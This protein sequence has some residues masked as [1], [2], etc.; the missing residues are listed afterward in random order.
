MSGNQ[1][2]SFF[3]EIQERFIWTIE[4]YLP[5]GLGNGCFKIRLLPKQ[6]NQKCPYCDYGKTYIHEH[7]PREI[8]GG[9]F[10]GV[11]VL[12]ALDQL[13]HM[14]PICGGTFV[15]IYDCVP[16][17]HGN[18]EE[19]E[20]Y[21]L[22]MLGSMPMTMI[23]SHL[24]LS[25]QTI[26]NRAKD[27]ADDEQKVM[28]N[29][30]YRYLSMDEVYIGRK[31]DGSHRIYWT[32]NDNSIPWKSNNVM[33]KIGR[34]KNEVIEYL[35]QLKHGDKVIAVS[36]DMWSAYRDAIHEALP[37]A[38]VVIDRYHVTE[39]AE[40]V[41]KS[42]LTSIVCPKEVKEALKEDVPLFLK[43]WLKLT[44][45]ELNSL[46]YYFSHDKRLEEVYYLIQEFMDFYN[47]PDYECALEYI[48][49]W[50]SKLFASN[51]VEEIRPLYDTLFNW[52][53]YI[54]NYFLY[55]ITNGR[56]EGKNNLLRQIDRMGFHYGLDCLQACLY[57]H[58]RNQELVKW[59]RHQH[60]IEL[61]LL[62][63]ADISDKAGVTKKE[64]QVAA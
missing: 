54:M 30:H 32:L 9:T 35:T 19:A 10:N 6:I 49:Q 2:N 31:K 17:M 61:K 53:P 36:I 3:D 11:P 52:F 29:C 64:N 47:Q 41:I 26:A 25:V 39:H 23:A 63:K 34:T 51:V 44:D 28:L 60:K 37:N 8:H 50:E 24:G 45:D 27:Y 7:K 4:N 42:A 5:Y 21:I 57:S 1:Y 14:C 43:Y 48:C 56:T 22:T 15:D 59:R 55:R 16:W 20:N 62:E 38:V 46:D 12:Y 58:D 33:I 18:T 40:K 13:R